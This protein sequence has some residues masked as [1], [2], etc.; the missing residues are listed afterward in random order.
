M[1]FLKLCHAFEMEHIGLAEIAGPKDDRRIEIAHRLCNI[2]GDKGGLNTD[3]IPWCA[4]WKTFVFVCVNI[5]LNPR[6]AFL[7]LSR[8]GIPASIIQEIFA[9]A[10]VD[11]DARL[12]GT[13]IPF[14]HPTWS[15]AASSWSMWGEDVPFS[16]AQESDI[17]VFSRKGGNHVTLL[18]E[19]KLGLLFIKCLGGNQSNMVCE[20]SHYLRTNLQSVRRISA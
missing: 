16:E 6:E 5:R 12:T 17:L 19:P 7:V 18:D 4:S 14:V 11:Y 1:N 10:G 3:E 13:G 8:R 2:E 9:F 15:A 20:S